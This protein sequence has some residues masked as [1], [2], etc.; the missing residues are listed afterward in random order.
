MPDEDEYDEPRGPVPQMPDEDDE[1]NDGPSGYISFLW[2][3]DPLGNQL[4]V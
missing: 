4:H 2:I 1:S 3:Y